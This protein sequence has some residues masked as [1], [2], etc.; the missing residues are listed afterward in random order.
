VQV[1]V[2]VVGLSF[3]S[4]FVPIFQKHPNVGRVGVCEVDLDMLQ[5]VGDKFGVDDRFTNLD[6][7]LLDDRYDAVHIA[8][9]VPLHVKQTLQVLGAGRHCAC[10]VPM[11]TDLDSIDR[12]IEAE[13]RTG[14]RYMM[15]ETCVY[16]REYLYA[17]DLYVRG[18]LGNLTFFKG[19]YHQD[20]EGAYPRYW[21]SQPPMHYATHIVSPILALAQTRATEVFCLG[22][23]KLRSDLQQPGGTT[24]PLQT[25]VMRL[26]KD[27]L[28]AELTRSWFQTARGYTEAFSVYGD[29]AGFEWQQLEDEDPIVFTLEPVKP[30]IRWRDALPERVKVPFRPD[31]IPTEIAEFTDGHS[32][33]HPHL[34]HEFI[35][36]IVED[37]PSAINA[38]VAAT[39]T[40]PGVCADLSSLQ[41]GK[42]V[43]IPDYGA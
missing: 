23:G 40:A 12:I 28:A 32:G 11:A 1:N 2:V 27:N 26:A 3:G 33:S 24:F 31:L 14:K 38:R 9:P 22:S 37:R 41:E 19:T 20:L 15:M 18:E 13:E 21:Y 42:G 35:R 16:T 29:K 10:A 7:V 30:E 39:W 36:S 4:A 5:R 17:R 43:L 8:T 34:V 6:E 25:A